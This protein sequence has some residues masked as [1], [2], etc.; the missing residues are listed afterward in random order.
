MDFGISTS[1]FYPVHTEDALEY[2]GKSGVKKCEVFLNT[3]S[4]TTPCFAKKLKAIADS[5]GLR[6]VSAHPFSSFAETFMLFSEYQRRFDDTL[7]Y[8][9][10]HF[11]IAAILGADI[12][13][14][15]G[16]LIPEKISRNEYFERF[17]RLIEAGKE[18]GIRVSPENVNRHLSQ[19][20]EFLKEMRAFLGSDF[21][22]VF[23]VKQAVRAGYDPIEFAEEFKKEIIHVHISDHDSEYDCLP[24]SKGHFDFRKLFTV[25]ES[26]DY[27]GSCVIELYRQ[28]FGEPDE[29]LKSLDFVEKVLKNPESVI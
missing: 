8:Y 17:A 18:F 1:C 24:P 15:H 22:L 3:M 19:N 13:V 12:S 14:I 16:A 29:L 4:E 6:I 25:L 7:E 9:K 2:L 5:Y 27:D 11:E 21:H 20:P 23:D 26:V 10:Q 28:N